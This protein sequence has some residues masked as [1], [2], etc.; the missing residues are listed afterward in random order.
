MSLGFS[1][2]LG[3]STNVERK[4]ENNKLKNFGFLVPHISEFEYELQELLVEI[5]MLIEKKKCEWEK[6]LKALERKLSIKVSENDR[7]QG[8][9]NEKERDL[10]DAFRRLEMVESKNPRICYGKQI[11]ELSHKVDAMKA[12]YSNLQRKY[13]KQLVAEKSDFSM[14]LRNLETENE[15]LKADYERLR[16][17]NEQIISSLKQQL[18]DQKNSTLDIQK[19]YGELQSQFEIKL[20]EETNQKN[21]IIEMK[22]EHQLAIDKLSKQLNDHKNTIK[23]QAEELMITK[24]S[25]TNKISE[26]HRLP[27][28]AE[29]KKSVINGSQKSVKR[30]EK[31][32][33]KRLN[34]LLHRKHN[35]TPNISVKHGQI[36]PTDLSSPLQQLQQALSDQEEITHKVK[37]L[38]NQLNEA[39]N[40][41]IDKMLEISRLENTCQVASATI[42]R[43]VESK[44]YSNGQ[45]KSLETSIDE[46]RE[47]V[48]NFERKLS[49]VEKDLSS[50]LSKTISEICRLKKYVYQTNLTSSNSLTNTEELNKIPNNYCAD[51]NSTLFINQSNSSTHRKTVNAPVDLVNKQIEMEVNH[52]QA[53]INQGNKNCPNF[54]QDFHS[55]INLLANSTDVCNESKNS[56]QS[57]EITP[58]KIFRNKDEKQIFPP[59]ESDVVAS[60]KPIPSAR[61]K[62]LSPSVKFLDDNNNGINSNENGLID[63]DKQ[64]YAAVLEP[65]LLTLNSPVSEISKFAKIN[66]TIIDSFPNS[67]LN[68]STDSIRIVSTCVP[69]FSVFTQDSTFVESDTNFHCYQSMNLSNEVSIIEYDVLEQ[70]SSFE[71]KSNLHLPSYC[72]TF[73]SPS[74]SISLYHS[75]INHNSLN[76]EDTNVYNLAAQFLVDEQKHSML[77]E[78][79][80][81]AHLKCLEEHAGHLNE[82]Y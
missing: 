35:S 36:S 59:G 23:L 18:A 75:Q 60:C 42:R 24:A 54:K 12:S 76:E 38:E 7:L 53:Q 44:A 62:L 71:K 70:S 80:I 3:Q 49:L 64:D 50:K 1:S 11:E 17:K 73:I 46:A 69:H 56:E 82:L 34:L 33:T 13:Q 79:K 77:L 2:S 26:I 41:L 40:T 30:Q 20:Q 47:R 66:E 19:R 8:L 5:D 57:I 14:H 22:E 6:D 58:N 4:L 48:G 45:T 52:S 31:T 67:C 21:N 78:Q 68:Y 10:Q 63:L 9:V 32:M 65:T 27:R 81:D 16:Q 39:N 55:N 28:E 25:L 51:L 43:L 72:S 37:Y 61:F 29:M 15:A 74:S